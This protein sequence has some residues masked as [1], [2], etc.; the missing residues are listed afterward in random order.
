MQKKEHRRH[1]FGLRELLLFVTA[2]TLGIAVYVLGQRSQKA[3]SE[4]HQLRNEVG[5]LSVKD[6]TQFH[7]IAVDS[8]EPDTWQWRVFVP[9]G[10]RYSWNIAY[11][12][13]PQDG[14]PRPEMTG[15]SNESYSDTA[16]EVLVTA[17]LRG[18][19]EDGW[20]LSVNSKIGDSKNQMSGASAVIPDEKM[21]WRREIPA[22]DGRVLGR[23]GQVSVSPKGPIILLQERACKAMPSG[24]YRPVPEPQPGFVVWL[25]EL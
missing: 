14:V 25:D 21:K 22:K 3:E 18:S 8:A 23:H 6:P 15:I 24:D 7:A 11:T 5:Q 4:L 20:R 19:K 1:S 17:R 10:H 16:N 12:N 2:I 9:K 13:I